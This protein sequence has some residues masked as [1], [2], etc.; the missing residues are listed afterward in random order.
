MQDIEKIDSDA[1]LMTRVANKDEKAYAEL[2]ALYLDKTYRSAV[3]MVQDQALAEDIAQE[4]FLKLWR[5]APNWKA[6]A[7]VGTWLYRVTHNLCIDKLRQSNRF[8]DAEVPEQEDPSPSP[9]EQKIARDQDN[10][11]QTAIAQLP[12]R[13]RMALLMVHFEE[14]T[15][16]EA[17]RRMD[18]SVDALESLLARARRKLKDLLLSKQAEFTG[19]GA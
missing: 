4:A 12:A 11:V 9:I 19:G 13:Q 8:S 17:A 10:L 16:I 18:I 5:Q 15:N 6:Q 1:Q 7:Q 14:T 3:V 2:M